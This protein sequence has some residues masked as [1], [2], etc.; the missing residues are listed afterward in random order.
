[1]GHPGRSR[2]R[3]RRG[4]GDD[5]G[6]AS[7]PDVLARRRL[8]FEDQ[9]G[10]P[11]GSPGHRGG[12]PT[13]LG[14]GEGRIWVVDQ[15]GQIYWIDPSGGTGSRGTDG[16]P[17][18]VAV[19]N[20]AVWITSGFGKAGGASGGVSRLDPTTGQ[21]TPAFDT[22]VG[23]EAITWG[24]D[25]LWVADANT[26]SVT[27]YNPV[28]RKAHRFTIGPSGGTVEPASILFSDLEGGT[29]W[30]GDAAGGRLYR[31]D[32]ADPRR[33]MTASVGG[34][35]SALAAGSDAIWGA[36]AVSDAVY[37]V[38]PHTA[39]LRTPV[40]VGKEG[41]N[42]PS[43]VAVGSGGVWVACSLSQEV[44]RIDQGSYAVTARVPVDGAPD[45]LVTDDHG[46]VWVAIRPR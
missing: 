37:V 15:R 5:R 18:G 21:L 22:S 16:T 23:S 42:A 6:H 33:V 34:A 2:G 40:D 43:A 17:T 24:A 32:A 12:Y 31:L 3:T 20:G 46:D 11:V 19:G 38:D 35:V 14:A 39:R 4:R 27:R 26:A 28:L 41:C 36:S 44:I 13:G 25:Q 45:A 29:V 7:Q 30:V 9:P 10:G 8:R 1:M